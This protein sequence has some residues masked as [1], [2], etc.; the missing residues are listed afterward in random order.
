MEGEKPKHETPKI[1]NVKPRRAF[2]RMGSINSGWKES[3]ANK[4]TLILHKSKAPQGNRQ[5]NIITYGALFL[6]E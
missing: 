4:D 6:Y 1:R 5:G 3:E 2:V